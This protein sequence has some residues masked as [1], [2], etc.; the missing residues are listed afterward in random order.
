MAYMP[1]GGLLFFC[2]KFLKSNVM[3]DRL[4]IL[5]LLVRYHRKKVPSQKD[6]DFASLPDEVSVSSFIYFVSRTLSFAFSLEWFKL[7]N[8]V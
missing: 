7:M 2:E 8:G 4:Q 1:V 6:E 5:A 3:S